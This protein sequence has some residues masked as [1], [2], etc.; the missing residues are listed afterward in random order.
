M[1]TEVNSSIRTLNDILYQMA[2]FAGG[3][4]P[5]ETDQEY[6][7]WLR[8]VAQKQEEYARRAFW[9]RCLTRE[10]ITLDGYTT[11]LPVRF[12]KPNG[13][14]MLI[15]DGVDWTEPDNSD[16]QS[17]FVEMVNDPDDVNFGRWQMRFLN[18]TDNDT[19]IIWYFSNPPK[20]TT[21]TDILLLPG[22][23]IGYAALVEHYR[24]TR[25]EG[26]QDEAMEQ[27]ENRFMEYLSI[28]TIPPKNELMVH[29][30]A[31]KPNRL[32]VARAYYATRNGRN[33]QQEKYVSTQETKTQ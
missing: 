25:A 14:Y 4:V 9:R 6:A 26:S 5:N 19:A 23:M 2:P 17:V 22:D 18:E 30:N 20:P 31:P 3:V 24:T 13:L 10:E 21:G 16:E 27:A 8:W 29:S 15:V 28:E 1:A 33:T 7:D 11:V 12:H 32:A